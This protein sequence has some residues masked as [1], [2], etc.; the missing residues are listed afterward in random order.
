MLL[1][2]VMF[3]HSSI[4]LPLSVTFMVFT[5]F[6]FLFL[7]VIV[8][9]SFPPFFL[10]LSLSLFFFLGLKQQQKNNSMCLLRCTSF[11]FII[12]MSYIHPFF[13][14]SIQ[15]ISLAQIFLLLPQCS[16]PLKDSSSFKKDTTT[17]GKY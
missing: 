1:F 5:S 10:C 4:F 11:F 8:F 13:L 7:F 9:F 15:N 17:F 2:K 16:H 12:M 6:N 3:R 14:Q